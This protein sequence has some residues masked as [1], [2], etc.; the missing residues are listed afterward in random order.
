MRA[1]S[2]IPYTDCIVFCYLCG[3]Q[4]E[5]ERETKIIGWILISSVPSPHSTSLSDRGSPSLISS[6]RCLPGSPNPYP[7][8]LSGYHHSLSVSGDWAPCFDL[9]AESSP[10]PPLLHGCAVAPPSLRCSP[11]LPFP[12]LFFLFF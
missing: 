8:L 11:L 2:I 1:G 10:P 12:C 6:D 3:N 9:E 4:T 7:I 5:R